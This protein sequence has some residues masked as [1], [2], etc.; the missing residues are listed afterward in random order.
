MHGDD[1]NLWTNPDDV[2]HSI[3]EDDRALMT[4][5]Q[6]NQSCTS[7]QVGVSLDVFYDRE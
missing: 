1:I 7:S 2:T 5:L 4:L 3:E 6:E